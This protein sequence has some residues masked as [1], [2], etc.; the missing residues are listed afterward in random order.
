[1]FSLTLKLL[2]ARLEKKRLESQIAKGDVGTYRREER[3]PSKAV[4]CGFPRVLLG[5]NLGVMSP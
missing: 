3:N 1:M 2:L 4:A 5:H